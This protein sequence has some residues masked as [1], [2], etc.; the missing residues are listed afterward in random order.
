MCFREYSEQDPAVPR[1]CRAE[2]GYALAIIDKDLTRWLTAML[3]TADIFVP[4]PTAQVT[5]AAPR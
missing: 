5:A 4:G 1:R 3:F 2:H